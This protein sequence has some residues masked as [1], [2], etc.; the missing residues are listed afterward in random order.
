MPPE[1]RLAGRFAISNAMTFVAAP[2][3]DIA[4]AIDRAYNVLA[5]EQQ[6]DGHW[7]FELEATAEGTLLRQWGQIGP[8]RSGLSYAIDAQPD[9]EERILEA[10]LAEHRTNMRATVEGVKALAEA[11]AKG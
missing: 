3:P 7:R 6:D 8:G 4:A 10:R 2:E 1:W 11:A 5:D 9:K